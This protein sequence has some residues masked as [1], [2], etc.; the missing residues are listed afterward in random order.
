[1]TQYVAYYRVSTQRQGDS[2]LGLEAQKRIAADYASL[3]GSI[4]AEYTEVQS[5]RKKKR[6]Q[7]Q[8][9]I[10]YAKQHGAV[11]LVAKF[12]RLSRDA[13]SIMELHNSEVN[14]ICCDMPDANT[15]TVAFM[16]GMAQYEHE[17]I[18]SRVRDAYASKRARGLGHTFGHA[19]NFSAETRALGAIARKAAAQLL[20]ANMRAWTLC[21]MMLKQNASYSQIAEMLNAGGFKTPKNQLFSKASVQRLR[22]LYA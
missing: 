12:D 9:A 4:I 14:F 18:S 5:G 15:L 6:P 22:K 3:R 13:A 8:A 7:L 20:P 19:A 1:M 17:K 2:G 10:D 11:L 16:A 21:S